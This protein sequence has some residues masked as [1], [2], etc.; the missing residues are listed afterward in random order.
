MWILSLFASYIGYI[1]TKEYLAFPD[2]LT[3]STGLVSLS[4]SSFIMFPFCLSGIYGFLKGQRMND[5]YQ[6][7][8][9]MTILSGVLLSIVYGFSFKVFFI[10]NI[11]GRG[12]YS[13]AGIPSGWMPGMA[14]KYVINKNLCNKNK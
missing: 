4:L 11:N 6:K 13:C 12:Y 10:S 2:V 8:A 5:K 1:S 14:T 9:M 7:V 3:Y